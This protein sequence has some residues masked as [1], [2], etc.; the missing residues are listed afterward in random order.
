[1]LPNLEVLELM[2]GAYWEKD[3]ESSLWGPSAHIPRQKLEEIPRRRSVFLDPSQSREGMGI[4]PGT[5]NSILSDSGKEK[6]ISVEMQVPTHTHT[7]TTK[8]MM[9]VPQSGSLILKIREKHIE[10]NMSSQLVRKYHYLNSSSLRCRSFNRIM[11]NG[12][13]E[14]NFSEYSYPQTW[15]PPY[16]THAAT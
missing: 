2:T 9:T 6:Q 13:A 11:K 1:M 3:L 4:I 5:T 8:H 16:P 10:N 7:H 14:I 12:K 15:L